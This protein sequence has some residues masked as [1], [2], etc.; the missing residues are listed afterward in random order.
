MAKTKEFEVDKLAEFV[1]QR[2][3]K[4]DEEKG[5]A[6]KVGA[7]KR[8]WNNYGWLLAKETDWSRKLGF[9]VKGYVGDIPEQ[10]LNA[11][12]N[13]K[14]AWANE[15]D[16]LELIGF[17]VKN[18]GRVKKCNSKALLSVFSVEDLETELTRSRYNWA[19]L[20]KILAFSSPESYY[21]Y[22]SRV[23]AVLRCLCFQW[24]P[25]DYCPFLKLL[26][27]DWPDKQD[28]VVEGKVTKIQNELD[29][30]GP[31]GRAPNG[32]Y[33]NFYLGKYCPLIKSVAQK[34]IDAG[35]NV[36]NKDLFPHKIEMALFMLVDTIAEELGV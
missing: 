11:R 30:N 31:Q 6:Y 34:Y 33:T 18:W 21:I 10:M 23:S 29:R 24:R 4:Y 8:F 9:P 17:I 16:R 22:D 13:F 1:Y 14:N 35:E 5:K 15:S 36:T 7:P 26:S 19:S 25:D 27:H 12:L 28:Q 3:C 32:T 2:L 20:T